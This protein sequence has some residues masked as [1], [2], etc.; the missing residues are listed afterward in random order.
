[1]KSVK[2]I[3]IIAT[4]ILLAAV[5][6]FA[7]IDLRLY[8]TYAIFAIAVLALVAFTGFSAATAGK[9]SMTAIIIGAALAGLVLL[10][11]FI[12]P[13]DDVRPD[14]YEKTGT[15][16]GWSAVIGAG[17]YTIY[18]LLGLFV[19]ML[20]FFGVKNVINK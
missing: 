18:S 8:V 10:F 16:L 2:S 15:S 4:L 1:M 5:M 17:L 12:T 6:L 11:Y 9:K 3:A 19:A 7:G 20:V 13:T 14:L